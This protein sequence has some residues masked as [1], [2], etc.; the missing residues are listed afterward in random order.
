VGEHLLLH[1]IDLRETPG[2]SSNESEVGVRAVG[3]PFDGEEDGGEGHSKGGI[4]R[5]YKVKKEEGVSSW[6]KTIEEAVWDAG[7]TSGSGERGM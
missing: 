2:R 7:R 1:G 6:L 5:F 3:G 4:S